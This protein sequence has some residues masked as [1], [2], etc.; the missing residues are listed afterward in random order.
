MLRFYIDVLGR[1]EVSADCCGDRYIVV[2]DV[3]LEMLERLLVI[4][5]L[6]LWFYLKH[7]PTGKVMSTHLL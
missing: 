1:L 4:L 3:P 5:V 7:V 2:E 6:S